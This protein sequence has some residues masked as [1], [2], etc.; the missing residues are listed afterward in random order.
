[1]FSIPTANAYEDLNSEGISPVVQWLRLQKLQM[2][3]ARVQSLLRELGSHMPHGAAQKS[4]FLNSGENTEKLSSK[5]FS[6]II[7]YTPKTWCK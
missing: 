6:N 7:I 1:M 2:K 5:I 3:G 4:S